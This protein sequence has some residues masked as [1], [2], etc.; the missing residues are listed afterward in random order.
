MRRQAQLAWWG[1]RGNEECWVRCCGVF[2]ALRYL[3]RE[4]RKRREIQ[5]Q[6]K[7]ESGELADMFRG[8]ANLQQQLLEIATQELSD[9]KPDAN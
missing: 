5:R 1:I 3:G 4:L 9:V 2:R 7:I 8:F 6:R